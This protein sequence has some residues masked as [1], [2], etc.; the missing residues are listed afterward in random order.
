MKKIICALILMVS[1]VAQASIITHGSSGGTFTQN[2]GLSSASFAHFDRAEFL[3]SS[4][5]VDTIT[6]ANTGS[7]YAHNHGSA[8]VSTVDVFDG[9]GWVNVFTSSSLVGN[10]PLSTLFASPITFS[11][12]MISGLRL[13]ASS[14]VSQMYHFA[15]SAMTYTLTGTRAVP[16]PAPLALLGLGMLVALVVRRKAA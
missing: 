16:T 6:I 2:N 11:G 14:P 7:G 9:T 10:V 5:Y 15:N 13:D 4:E 12:M 3:F 1:G 8:A